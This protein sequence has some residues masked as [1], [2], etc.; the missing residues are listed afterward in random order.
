[1][2]S[3]FFAMGVGVLVCCQYSIAAQSQTG[4]VRVHVRAA[5]TP[6]EDAEVIVAGPTLT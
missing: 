1:M 3:L 6:I 2:R 5:Q 4:T